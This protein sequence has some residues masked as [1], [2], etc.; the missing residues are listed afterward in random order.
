ML[1]FPTNE[2]APLIGHDLVHSPQTEGH[3]SPSTPSTEEPPAVATASGSAQGVEQ[4]VTPWDVQGAVVEGVQV[5]LTRALLWRHAVDL[6]RCVPTWRGEI[7][8]SSSDADFAFSLRCDIVQMAIDYNHLID[9]FGTKRID[10]ELL[11]RFERLTGRKPHLL[12]R[13]E[14]FFSHR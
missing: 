9:Q 2:R 4:V 14:T 3:V 5:R 6:G 12:L 7:G 10:N 11:E 1:A 13:R 8:T